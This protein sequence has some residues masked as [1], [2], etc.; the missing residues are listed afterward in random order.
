MPDPSTTAKVIVIQDW[1]WVSKGTQRR[2]VPGI[3]GVAG[4]AQ[5]ALRTAAAFVRAWNQRRSKPLEL[6]DDPGKAIAVYETTTGS[7]VHF[8]TTTY[9]GRVPTPED[10]AQAMDDPVALDEAPGET[11]TFDPAIDRR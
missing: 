8:E 9:Y 10:A 11:L 4:S 7:R 1:H 3:V 5:D 2:W 6:P